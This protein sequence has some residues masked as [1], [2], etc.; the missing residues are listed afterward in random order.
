[1]RDKKVYEKMKKEIR[2]A[3]LDVNHD[4]IGARGVVLPPAERPAGVGPGAG[5]VGPVSVSASGVRAAGEGPRHPLRAVLHQGWEALDLHVS[6]GGVSA[7]ISATR[8][9]EVDG[10]PSVKGGGVPKDTDHA[11]VDVV[12]V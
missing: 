3:L 5:P 11:R 12:P 6:G 2:L 8:F 1:M 9:P 4:L 7:E 10:T